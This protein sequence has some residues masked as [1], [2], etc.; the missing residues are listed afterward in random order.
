MSW[1]ADHT[2]WKLRG[3]QDDRPDPLAASNS[4]RALQHLLHRR[5][6]QG[7][8]LGEVVQLD[9]ADLVVDADPD[10][11]AHGESEPFPG[12][13]PARARPARPQIAVLDPV[14]A[15]RHVA[16]CPTAGMGAVVVRPTAVRIPTG[17][18]ASPGAVAL[19]VADDQQE[20]GQRRE[21]TRLGVELHGPVGEHA[22]PEP[23]L[24]G[25]RTEPHS[26]RGIG[27]PTAALCTRRARMAS[28]TSRAERVVHV[29]GV[30]TEQPGVAQPPAGRRRIGEQIDAAVALPGVHEG[31]HHQER[32][33]R[34][35]RLGIGDPGG[36]R[37]ETMV[38]GSDRQNHLTGLGMTPIM[39][40][41]VTF[42][43]C[44]EEQR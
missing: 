14:A 11:G 2:S 32:H 33:R 43:A 24:L 4:L 12:R 31:L 29:L 8:P 7:V 17:L 10:S 38:A 41:V 23:A 42:R 44:A 39:S 35:F 16:P 27:R 36:E 19:R 22:G 18:Q 26:A 30:G 9:R 15:D 34:R 25:Q 40:L 37:H 20:P 28:R 5:R 21:R 6:T 3:S 1:P 13:H